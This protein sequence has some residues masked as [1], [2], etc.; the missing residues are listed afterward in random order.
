M[1]RVASVN[2][3]RET[4]PGEAEPTA[5]LDSRG[6]RIG[7]VFVVDTSMSMQPYILRVQRMIEQVYTT[8]AARG[9]LDRVSFGLVGF[10]AA[11]ASNPKLEYTTKIFQPLELSS[12]PET[13]LRRV[14]EM[15]EATVP[16][17]QWQEDAYAGLADAIDRMNWDPFQVRMVVLVSDAGPMPGNSSWIRDPGVNSRVIGDRA[18]VRRISIFPVHLLTPQSMKQDALTARQ[19]Y[20]TLAEISGSTKANYIAIDAGSK[21]TFAEQMGIISKA[22]IET[23]ETYQG[24]RQISVERV[25]QAEGTAALVFNEIFRAQFEYLAS[26]GPGV[27]PRYEPLWTVDVDLT[28][29]PVRTME[30]HIFLNRSQ[31]NG[32][33]Q[34]TKLVLE[35]AKSSTLR[36]SEF[37]KEIRNIAA[38]TAIGSG[39]KAPGAF[40]DLMGLGALPALLK[41][42]PYHSQVL[43][44]SQEVWRN[45]S[46]TQRQQFIDE[47][48]R[49]LAAYNEK[50]R[51]NEAWMDLGGGDQKN[52]KL[53]GESTLLP[54][55]DLP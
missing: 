1:A 21:E 24:G 9:L 6:M 25:R 54:L 4:N 31:L 41:A 53:V 27:M 7:M 38:G 32:L 46:A 11:H 30:P 55:R 23:G 29:P 51:D 20:L 2:T 14:S 50:D 45:Q 19:E 28:N 48:E 16:T 15:T 33:A 37:Y 26:A 47:L 17:P 13:L 42:L 43:S 18:S 5:R 44:M 40:D 52:G 12:R 35:Q 3:V 39:S 36:S 49:K 10:R 22:I 8:F 34:A